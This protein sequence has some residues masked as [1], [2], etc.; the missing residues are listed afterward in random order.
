M[1]PDPI[2]TPNQTCLESKKIPIQRWTHSI[3]LIE[4]NSYPK[5]AL[6]WISTI[7]HLEIDS[8]PVIG[9]RPRRE[10]RRNRE[11]R[12]KTATRTKSLATLKT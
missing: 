8:S 5:S 2:P 4:P 9:T 7:Q 10:V 1:S 11:M 3:R 6:V 12:T